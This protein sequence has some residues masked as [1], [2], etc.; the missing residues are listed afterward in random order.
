[1]DDDE[2]ALDRDFVRSKARAGL[3][4]ARETQVVAGRY[5]L[6]ARMGE[7]GMGVVYAAHDRKL[8]RKVALKLVKPGA[9]GGEAHVRVMREAQ[10]L[11]GLAHPNVVTVFDVGEH[12]GRLFVAMEFVDGETLT[13]WVKRARWSLGE[14]RRVMVGAARGLAA[15]HAQGL[16]HRD[17]KPDNVM[18]ARDRS[19]KVLDFGLVRPVGRL[20]ENAT[21]ENAG[22]P[23]DVRITRGSTVLGTPVYMAPEQL[24]G[25]DIDARADQYSFS[26][27]LYEIFYGQLP[28]AVTSVAELSAAILEGQI[29]P[30][31][32]GTDVPPAIAHAIMRGLSRRAA[33]RYE[34]MTALIGELERGAARRP[35]PM[36][37]I[38]GGSTVALLA[39]AVGGLMR[40]P[41]RAQTA[42][43]VV[44]GVTQIPVTVAVDSG[45]L[46]SDAAG[47][48][49]H[50]THREAPK[51]IAT[52][53]NGDAGYSQPKAP[54]VYF[55]RSSSG[56]TAAFYTPEGFASLSW[57]IGDTGPFTDA[58]IL[59]RIDPRTQNR[60][61]LTEISFS[62]DTPATTLYYRF[63]DAHGVSEGP[64]AV[65]FSPLQELQRQE[66]DTLVQ[67]RLEWIHFRLYEG[68]LFLQYGNLVSHRC[69]IRQVRIGIDKPTP[70]QT[71]ALPACDVHDPY[72]ESATDQQI[73]APA[74]ASVSVELTY[75]DGKRSGVEQF[76]TSAH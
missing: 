27:T 31:P 63:V 70:D 59:Y 52:T 12:E 45:L 1:V 40:Y 71:L 61:P 41:G 49:A 29:R 60:S 38:A 17:F 68:R 21:R 69:G 58:P 67:L 28:Y 23:V 73:I 20:D 51:P 10:A 50:V 7:G 48:P 5:M 2:S 46:R 4:G 19:V 72:S 33:D 37:W 47:E 25:G 6:L 13:V 76:R 34:S 66:H 53:A 75:F 42:A 9:G 8:D 15:A 36:V 22:L 30:P 18:V 55:S 74:T 44:P 39:V 56:W 32:S 3:F 57:R 35:G 26:V 54:T 24:E 14:V 62:K 16:V 65:Q 64:F 11:A 43:I